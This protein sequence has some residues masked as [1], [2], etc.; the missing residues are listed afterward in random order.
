MR[1]MA[2]SENK[3]RN[4]VILIAKKRRPRKHF[5]KDTIISQV[6]I[7]INDHHTHNSNKINMVDKLS[8]AKID[9]NLVMM[10]L[11]IDK[12]ADIFQAVS[13]SFKTR[14]YYVN[15]FLIGIIK[16][17][18]T[19]APTARFLVCV[20]I[21]L[22]SLPKA[23]ALTFNTAYVK[24]GAA[25]ELTECSINTLIDLT[26]SSSSSLSC[27]A[28]SCTV[29]PMSIFRQTQARIRLCTWTL[30]ATM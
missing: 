28:S 17:K 2:F 9:L 30:R 22:L 11:M 23:H 24:N 5:H 21:T 3:R 7:K 18:M 1:K 19:L 4:R 25:L 12:I 13:S 16:S 10:D 8:A 6:S 27:S 26:F 29:V 20:V 15:K 14:H